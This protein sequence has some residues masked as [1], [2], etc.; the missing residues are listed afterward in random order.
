MKGNGLRE[1]LT[2][3]YIKIVTCLVVF[4]ICSFSVFSQVNEQLL[5]SSL[6]KYCRIIIS[7]YEQHFDTL[8]IPLQVEWIDKDL[9]PVSDKNSKLLLRKGLVKSSAESKII[10]LDFLQQ[11]TVV[12]NQSWLLRV[13]VSKDFNGNDIRFNFDFDIE[14][15]VSEKTRK[16]AGQ[17]LLFK[18]PPELAC[19]TSIDKKELVRE[20][21]MPPE[22]RLISPQADAENLRVVKETEV[23]VIGYATDASGIN[24]VLV[25]SN[26]A[27][28]YPDGKFVTT[29]KLA[30]GENEIR[31][32]AIDN[33]GSI[34]EER[35]T[36]LCDSYEL[37]L[38]MLNA[39]NYYALIIAVEQYEDP[40]ISDLDHSIDDA[41][42]LLNVLVKYYTFEKENSKMLTNPRFEDM[43]IELDRLNKVVTENDNLLI[44]FAGHGIWSEQSKVGYWLPSDARDSNTANWFRNSTL[45]DYIGGIRSKHTLLIADACFSGSIFKS[46]SAFANAPAAIEKVYDLPSRKAMTSGS[47]SEV[48]DKSI[49]LEYLIKRLA[50][51]EKPYLTSEELFYSMKTA[52]I[53]NS[54]TIPQFGEILNTGDEGGDFIFIRKR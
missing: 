36:V 27:R 12:F 53:N 45:R 46:R 44:F 11:N 25:N 38:Q 15:A 28:M 54:P 17:P 2:G 51:N 22:I 18:N 1:V 21:N 43:V 39:G 33:D 13:L 42:A 8:K 3:D 19:I 24:L 37:A 35:I 26:D 7:K 23:D 31:I 52:I 5:A 49:F 6:G 14:G 4:V 20:E 16:S 9:Q 40:K 41:S 50:E 48:P 30:P 29:V 10:Y 47:L 34:T 32:T